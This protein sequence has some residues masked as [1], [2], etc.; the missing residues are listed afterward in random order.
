M[1]TKVENSELERLLGIEKQIYLEAEQKM[2]GASAGIRT[3]WTMFRDLQEICETVFDVVRQ[4]S[5]ELERQKSINEDMSRK[6]EKQENM[7]Q[8][9]KRRAA[10][11]E[12]LELDA[13]KLAQLLHANGRE[14]DSLCQEKKN[15]KA[16]RDAFEGERDQLICEKKEALEKAETYKKEKDG[17]IQSRD[18]AIAER[19]ELQKEIEKK[20]QE[21][22]GKEN[23]ITLKDKDIRSYK[24]ELADCRNEIVRLTEEKKDK[25]RS[26]NEEL[27]WLR[28]YAEALDD[29]V[30]RYFRDEKKHDLKTHYKDYLNNPDK[31]EEHRKHFPEFDGTEKKK[32]INPIE[33]EIAEE[34]WDRQE[35]NSL[36]IWE[37]RGE[38]SGRNPVS[39]D[40]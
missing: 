4:V 27:K 21:L 3:M 35:E 9:Y 36:K 29:K 31:W 15:L 2:E 18:N 22:E 30:I 39:K 40:D 38:V 37:D 25:V 5:S 17:A 20:D 28:G 6:L 19:K 23:E 26:L 14:R 12:E 1:M 16:E 34:I 32:E 10:V 7:I 13:A 33:D 8:E 24:E 11:Y